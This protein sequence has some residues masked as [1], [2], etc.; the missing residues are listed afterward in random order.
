MVENLQHVRAVYD[1]ATERWEIHLVCKDGIKTPTAPGDE[2]AGID[3]GISNFAAVAYGT[4]D[5]DLYPGNRLKQTG[6]TSPKR[7]LNISCQPKS[8]RASSIASTRASISSV[9]L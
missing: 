6:T 4:E 2:T 1:N 5:A 9:V 8:W 7:S 3:L